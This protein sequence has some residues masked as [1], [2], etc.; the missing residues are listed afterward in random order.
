MRVV[1]KAKW[2][3]IKN[4]VKNIQGTKPKSEHCVQNAVQRVQASGKKGV[5]MTNYKNCGRKRKLSPAEEKKVVDAKAASEKKVA[6]ASSAADQNE[7]DSKS[8]TL[9]QSSTQQ[10]AKRVREE[11][12]PSPAVQSKSLASPAS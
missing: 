11:I 3:D 12:L 1:Q 7:E 10:V 4:K 8:P 6:A 5:A 9:N 2:K